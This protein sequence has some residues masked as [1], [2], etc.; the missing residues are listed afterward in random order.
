MINRL[1]DTAF[2][3]NGSKLPGLRVKTPADLSLSTLS[4]D[5]LATAH[6]PT[7]VAPL[8][9]H[10]LWVE[11]ELCRLGRL[12]CASFVANGYDVNLWSYGGLT[13]IPEGVTLR[14]ARDVLPESRIFRYQ[15]GT[16]EKGSL[17]PFA[18][19]FRLALLSRFG[20]LWSDADV[21]CL[22]PAQTLRD[23]APGGFFVS[24]R[25][26]S[27]RAVKVN[28]NLI[29]HPDPKPGDV[30]DLAFRFAD[31]FDPA[32]LTWTDCGPRLLTTL[33]DTWPALAPPMLMA[34][35][36]VNPIDHWQCPRALFSP[37]TRL[38]S[39]T[40][41]LHCYNEIWRRAGIDKS[42]PFPP[43]SLLGRIAARYE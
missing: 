4:T 9:V 43:N 40:G 2:G 41:F 16:V 20:G 6:V 15:N 24:E 11:G 19:L 34:P 23:S 37:R 39:T 7:D 32:R 42:A 12:T 8:P 29:Y 27:R 38:P 13:R 36:V 5:K 22:T 14:D 17:S 31:G 1:L 30:I 10:I 25:L 3:P 21:I 33:I 18:N 26:R 28:N 35:D